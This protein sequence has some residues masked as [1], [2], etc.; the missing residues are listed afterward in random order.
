VQKLI[1]GGRS[2]QELKYAKAKAKATEFRVDDNELTTFP[3]NSDELHYTSVYVIS[4]YANARIAGASA[5][6]YQAELRKV[7]SFYDAASNDNGYS[8]YADG[9]WLLAM[10]AYFLV[11]NFGSAKV[12]ASHVKIPDF[13][14]EYGEILHSVVSFLLIPNSNEPKQL[15]ALCRFLRG[16]DVSENVVHEEA[17]AY[18][19]YDNPEDAFFGKVLFVAIG[20][21]VA[22]SSRKLLPSFTGVQLEKWKPYLADDSSSKL[23]W[24]AQRRIGEAGIL[25]G[26][27]AFVQLPTGTGKTKSIEI[28]LRARILSGN[29]RMAVIVA[30]LRALCTEIANELGSSLKGTAVVQLASDVL[31]IDPWMGSHSSETSIMVFTPE[32]LGYVLH[33][34]PQLI[35]DAD[36]FVFDEA[37]LLDDESRGPNYELLLTEIFHKKPDAQK[38]LISAVVSNPEDISH[39]AFGENG[40]IVHDRSIQVTEK[41]I[42]YFSRKGRLVNYIDPLDV[43]KRDYFLK[44]DILPTPLAMRPGERRERVFPDLKGKSDAKMRRDL[45]IYYANRLL[46]NGA[47]AIYVPKKSSIFPLFQRIDEIV[48]RGGI[49]ANLQS[50]A[51]SREI[52]AI[53]SLIEKHYGTNNSLSA[54]VLS[55]IL[56]H[57]G[58]LQGAIRQ[59]VEY[60]VEHGRASCIACTSTLAEGVNLPI[61]YLLVTD[62]MKNANEPRTRDFQNLAGRT[63]RSGKFSE[64]SVLIL[65][66]ILDRAKVR[67][68]SRLF[69][70]SIIEECKSSIGNLLADAKY[71]EAGR[72]RTIPGNQIASVILE[73]LDDP[74]LEQNLAIA[75]KKSLR[76]NDYQAR[77][78]SAHRVKPLE[79]IESYLSNI[80]D[81]G[82][83]EKDIMETAT[84]TFAYSSADDAVQEQL[85]KLFQAIFEHL[86]SEPKPSLSICSKTRVGL[87]KTD[88]LISW[89]STQPAE[90]FFASGCDQ[91]HIIVDEFLSLRPDLSD[92]YQVPEFTKA[93]EMW[94]DGDSLF[95]IN[96]E[97]RGSFTSCSKLS[98]P[99][100]ERLASNYISYSFGHFISCLIDVVSS[101]ESDFIG[102]VDQLQDLQRKVKYGV[103]NAGCSVICEKVLNDRIIAFDVVAILN[104]ETARSLEE[105][106]LEARTHQDALLQ[107]A[108]GLPSFCANKLKLLLR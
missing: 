25:S 100:T 12:A 88:S 38:V 45:A 19:H 93:V 22:S 13:Y 10:A 92:R 7:A 41:A 49:L 103:P 24:Q 79:A 21:A 67:R 54:G 101:E 66:D 106:K 27:N 58:D 73:H 52:G 87:R 105:V 68:Y 97:L 11:G 43:S 85:L 46:P 82:G 28:L 83:T 17:S 44:L 102:N 91:L 9:Y 89:T 33:H 8:Q 3:L 4:S 59:S 35:D 42:G 72:V 31:E 5:T 26:T 80:I 81:A 16:E 15:A 50:S 76:C 6:E 37:H 104:C 74:D 78:L 14:G 69:D 60:A 40:K 94:I 63:A 34:E 64:G 1:L 107:Y 99:K 2:E 90:E 23:L 30:P 51:D 20:D 57:Y 62:V 70:P 77:E 71:E 18:L 39:W 61:K 32:K 56:P 86:S 53:S 84:S 29:C 95:S 47:C 108:N 55:G 65:D 75:L 36:L 48:A 96:E 98:I